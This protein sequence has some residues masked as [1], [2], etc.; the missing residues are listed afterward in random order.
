V[1]TTTTTTE[2]AVEALPREVLLF[3]VDDPMASIDFEASEEAVL[4][5]IDG[6]IRA[7]DLSK[8]GFDDYLGPFEGDVE[9]VVIGQLGP[10]ELDPRV[11]AIRGRLSDEYDPDQPA[12]DGECI[13]VVSSPYFPQPMSCGGPPGPGFGVRDLQNGSYV[14]LGQAL[15]NSSVVSVRWGDQHVWQR[16]RGGYYFVEIANPDR[17]QVEL[18]VYD[19]AGDVQVSLGDLVRTCSVGPSP[20]S[21]PRDDLPIAVD[22]KIEVIIQVAGRCDLDL[23]ADIAG[24]N[25]TASFGGGDPAE[26]WAYE[27]ENGYEPM[28]WLMKVLDL[29]HGTREVDGRTLYIWPAAAAHDGDWDTIPAEYIDDLR[30]IYSEEDFEGF[31]QFGAYIGYRVGIYESGDW[32]FFVAGD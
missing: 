1:E 25:F 21:Y 26:L 27:E 22:S 9:I 31:R 10:D 17:H 3:P 5:P 6:F 7:A 19:T 15:D 28:A 24:P 18:T 23:L 4:Y 29:P 32:S 20:R 11:Y 2:P 16:T 30:A 14:F 12:F 13:V 8:L